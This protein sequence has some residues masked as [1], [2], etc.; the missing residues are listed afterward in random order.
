MLVTTKTLS[1]AVPVKEAVTDVAEA[2]A[3]KRRLNSS[4]SGPDDAGA[5][6]SR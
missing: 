3:T 5:L 4:I 6:E 2:E 1:F